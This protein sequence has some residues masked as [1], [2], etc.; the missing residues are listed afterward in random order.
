M[1]NGQYITDRWIVHML[2]DAA[3]ER[4]IA[5]RYFSNDWL[6]ELQK[7]EKI[8]RVLGYKFDINNSVASGIAQD[9]VAAYEI[10][11]AQNIEAVPHFLIRTKATESRWRDFNWSKGIVI[12]PLT[13][14]S[15]HGVE[16]F[17]DADKAGEI[18]QK[19]GIQAWAASPF[20]KITREIRVVLLDDTV[21]VGY[22]KEPVVHNGLRFF[23]LGKGAKAVEYNLTDKQTILAAKARRALGL[24]L[25]A[26]DIIEIENGALQVL[27][28]NDGIMM[29]NYARQSPQN[30]ALT[31][32]VYTA[33]LD[34]LF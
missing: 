16:L 5:I 14:T 8:S 9:K 34:A 4:G 13:G 22:E 18:M 28:V 6:L 3:T 2:A 1:Q 32:G 19:S 25:C 27:E 20:L 15:G 31:K 12:K 29:E 30:K 23:N 24:R 7:N 21:L 17:Y 33:I 26:V 10:L 11:H